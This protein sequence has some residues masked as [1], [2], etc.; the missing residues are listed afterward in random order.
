MEK[1]SI[2]ILVAALVIVVAGIA[3]YYNSTISGGVI[4]RTCIDTDNGLNFE[5]RGKVLYGNNIFEDE[6]RTSGY[7]A[8][9][10]CKKNIYSG[11]YH[12]AVKMHVCKN[13]C[14]EGACISE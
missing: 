4:S 7:V 2:L 6:C 5:T 8:E 13:G 3:V 12:P 10:Y 1:K 11:I 9:N 14:N